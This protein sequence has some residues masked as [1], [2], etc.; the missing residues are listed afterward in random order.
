M[1][2][3]FVIVVYKSIICSK[4]EKNGSQNHI[5]WI[6]VKN[7]EDAGKPKKVQDPGILQNG[8]NCRQT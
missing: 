5:C 6:E 2:T 7:V 3:S 4:C 8:Q 1:F